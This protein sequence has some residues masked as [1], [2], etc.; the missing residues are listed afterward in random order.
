MDST[1]TEYSTLDLLPT[2]VWPSKSQM[3]DHSC[4]HLRDMLR[5]P[6][7]LRAETKKDSTGI[8]RPNVLRTISTE[9]ASPQFNKDV[10]LK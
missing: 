3:M 7:Q 9:A 8:H 6:T 10:E 5:L 4:F 1:H 2:E